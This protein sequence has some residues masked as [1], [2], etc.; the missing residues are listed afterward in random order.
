MIFQLKT[1]FQ[2]KTITFGIF[3]SFRCFLLIFLNAISCGRVP[4][5]ISLEILHNDLKKNRFFLKVLT[6][7]IGNEYYL[8]RI[9]KRKQAIYRFLECTKKPKENNQT[10][11]SIGN[12]AFW[13]RI[14]KFGRIQMNSLLSFHLMWVVIFALN[15]SFC[16]MFRWLLVIIDL[17]FLFGSNKMFQLSSQLPSMTCFALSLN[18]G[19]VFIAVYSH[20]IALILTGS[21]F[22][23][24]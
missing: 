6:Y 3:F 14:F 20:R 4:I 23:N 22:R 15:K 18:I 21:E 12:V 19:H 13:E 9:R 16:S 11:K 24:L 5:S 17:F 2:L 7:L 8:N 1:K 10:N